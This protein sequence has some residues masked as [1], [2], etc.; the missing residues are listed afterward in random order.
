MPSA[1]CLVPN[2]KCLIVTLSDRAARGEYEDLSGPEIEK[3]LLGKFQSLEIERALIGDEPE[4]L[5][6]Q[7]QRTNEFDVIITTGGT[8]IGPRD[9]T[10]DVVNPMLDKELPGIME[11]IRTKHG[12]RLPSAL[13]SRSVAGVIDTT[14]IYTLPGSVKAV[15]EYMEEIMRSMEHALNMLQ[16]EGH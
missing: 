14:L 13:L 4:A 6:A 8:G 12:E 2:M 9:I 7:V 10:P 5:K 3:L 11:F 16:G 15:C 1:L